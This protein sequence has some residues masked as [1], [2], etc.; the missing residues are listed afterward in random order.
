MSPELNSRACWVNGR[1]NS[2]ELNHITIG[3]FVIDPQAR[4]MGDAV[5][6]AECGAEPRIT[7]IP[8]RQTFS[9]RFRGGETHEENHSRA[10]HGSGLRFRLVKVAYSGCQ[11]EAT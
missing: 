9:Y 5:E 3:W 4:P 7:G 8:H 2:Y 6:I 10:M 11:A 1:W